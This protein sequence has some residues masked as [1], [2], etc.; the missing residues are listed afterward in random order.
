MVEE[1]EVGGGEVWRWDVMLYSC[2]WPAGGK[3]SKGIGNL[4]AITSEPGC[5]EVERGRRR[6]QRLQSSKVRKKRVG[7]G[8]G[9]SQSGRTASSTS[10]IYLSGPPA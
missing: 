10:P 7:E 6:M 4:T 1:V 2:G 5:S 3:R 9:I 8:D